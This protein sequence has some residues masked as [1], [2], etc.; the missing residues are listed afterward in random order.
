MKTLSPYEGADRDW[1]PEDDVGQELPGRPRR[2]YLNWR[3]ATLVALIVGA[4]GFYVGIRVEKSHAG[5]SS[6]A[7][8]GFAFPGAASGSRAGAG[9]SAA[10]SAAGR[11][12]G[13]GAAAALL[14]GARGLPGG[15]GAGTFGTVSSVSAN[16]KYLYVTD[17]S[18]N[19]VKVQLSSATKISKSV[20]A[21][22]HSLHP[23]DAVVIGGL[24]DK[25]G[26][27]DATSVRDSGATGLGSSGGRGSGTGGS[28]SPT[29]GAAAVKSLFGNG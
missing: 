13:G 28:A 27:V 10:G 21:S 20:S 22:K 9:A 11:S 18:G 15:A 1:E 12:A 7:T 19:T 29:S 26:T 2:Q 6:G 17:A 3:S 24:T 14:G 5:N 16:G 25:Q 23:G 8:R 4:V